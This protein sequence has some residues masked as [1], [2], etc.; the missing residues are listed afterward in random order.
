MKHFKDKGK[1]V[2]GVFI[3]ILIVASFMVYLKLN[4]NIFVVN[5]LKYD[6]AITD[7]KNDIKEKTKII[8]VKAGES[9]RLKI[10]LSLLNEDITNYEVSYDLYKDEGTKEKVIDK[11]VEV[12]S[13]QNSI[14][15]MIK[16]NY[17]RKTTI[18]IRNRSDK[19]YYLEFRINAS[20]DELALENKIQLKEKSNEPEILAIVDGIDVSSFPKSSNYSVELSCVDGDGNPITVGYVVEYIEENN[21]GWT[22]NLEN[23]TSTDTMC[24]AIFEEV[25]EV[26]YAQINNSYWC[27]NHTAN[28]NPLMRYTGNCELIRSSSGSNN[29]KIRFLTSGDLTLV[30]GVKIDAFLV[31]GGGGSANNTSM[32]QY[33]NG[34]GGGGYTRTV[35]DLV[36]SPGT[37]EVV[38]GAGGVAGANG[39]PTTVKK[40]VGTNSLVQLLYVNG[41]FTPSINT[42]SSYM[43]GGSGGSG[44]GGAAYGYNNTQIPSGGTNAGAGGANGGDGIAGAGEGGS[45]QGTTTCEFGE[46]YTG[47]GTGIYCRG[48]TAADKT[49]NLYSGGGGGGATGY[50]GEVNSWCPFGCWY[51]RQEGGTGG[52]GGGGTGVH[53]A[54]SNDYNGAANTGGGGGKGGSGGSGILVIRNSGNLDP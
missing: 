1:F 39:H 23:I 14:S 33:G 22:F 20:K 53:D 41:G 27:A 24:Y 42:S 44:G 16:K 37:Y 25:F 21:Q 46:E 45:G 54:P 28:T 15:G 17:K 47:A 12:F 52:A 6:I 40:R 29:W 8:K 49:K 5:G 36:L 19:D 32:Q 38:I 11:N 34:G 4:E 30:S 2:V 50:L 35:N 26:V 9:K 3:A 7:L 13:Y 51:Y 43:N 31:G 48:G 18:E 10:L